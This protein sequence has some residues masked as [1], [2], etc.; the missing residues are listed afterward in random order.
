MKEQ[1]TWQQGFGFGPQVHVGPKWVPMC[2]RE[3]KGWKLN[4]GHMGAAYFWAYK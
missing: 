4:E 3:G 2:Q 1:D